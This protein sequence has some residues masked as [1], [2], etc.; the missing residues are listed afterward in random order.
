MV[1]LLCGTGFTVNF[2]T[3]LARLRGIQGDSTLRA[4]FTVRLVT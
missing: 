4:Y 2:H 3:K 1:E